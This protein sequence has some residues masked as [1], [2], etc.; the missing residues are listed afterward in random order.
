M[1]GT[2]PDMDWRV[3]KTMGSEAEEATSWVEREM[4]VRLT[5]VRRGGG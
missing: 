5:K 2:S 3:V 1:G 4:S